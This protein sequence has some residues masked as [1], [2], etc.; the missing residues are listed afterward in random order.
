MMSNI[1]YDHQTG[2]G[3][4]TL[5]LPTLCFEKPII[6]SN[7]MMITQYYKNSNAVTIQKLN[8]IVDSD[9]CKNVKTVIIDC[10][11]PRV[12]SKA[13]KSLLKLCKNKRVVFVGHPHDLSAL[14][15]SMSLI[16][17]TKDPKLKV[18]QFNRFQFTRRY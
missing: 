4:R 8:N 12:T 2:D 6:I 3:F 16:S 14:V 18:V 17:V 7:P 13:F 5:M 10:R 15:A 1:I 11:I 9:E